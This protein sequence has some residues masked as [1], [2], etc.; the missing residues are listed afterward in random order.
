MKKNSHLVFQHILWRGLYF[1]SVLLI[2]IGIARFFAA[3]KSGQIFYIVNNLAFVLLVV[4]LSFESG[5]AFYIASGKVE[6][7][8]MA[9]LSLLWAMA[10]SMIGLAL[11]WSI[12]Y[13]SHSIYLGDRKFLLAS[14]FFI[15]G[16]LITTYFT[17]LFYAKKEFGLPNKILFLVNSVL[18]FFLTGWN[19]NSTVSKHFIEIYFFCFFLQGILLAVFFIKKHP[20]TGMQRL[21]PGTILKKVIDYSLVALVA[22]LIYFLVNRI[23][24]WFVQYFCSSKDFGNYIQASKLAQ[25]LF[26]LPGILGSTLFPIFSASEKSESSQLPAVIRV[27]LCLNGIICI[28]FLSTGWYLI[29]LIFGA[30]F[31]N[32][33]LLFILLIPG[34]LGITMTYPLAAW[35]SA[36]KRIN[37]NIRG[38]LVALSVIV[39]GDALILPRYGI[40][41]APVIS[42]AGYFSY[43]WYC[44]YVYRKQ[45]PF[46]LKDF[47]IIRHSDLKRIRQI[48][49][50]KLQETGAGN[51][52]L[53]KSSL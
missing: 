1:F 34:I 5:T 39:L 25:M 7:T 31:N 46:P 15:L 43:F 32:M 16:V 20:H 45:N 2:N 4:S 18:I 33:Y 35:F 17:A 6:A 8:P 52:M 19:K 22:N 37:V 27:L 10:A 26:I 42:S 14:F 13:Y 23:D 38:S 29:P 49:I 9:N 51:S 11:W 40:L 28:L 50:N 44:I 21:P 53:S 24:Y 41:A 48:L 36:A 30:S 47:F 12:L 3:E